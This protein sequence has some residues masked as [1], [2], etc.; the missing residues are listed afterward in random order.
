MHCAWMS[1]R[2]CVF[3]WILCAHDVMPDA[4]LGLGQGQGWAD[5]CAHDVLPD[6]PL[7]SSFSGIPTKRVCLGTTRKYEEQLCTQSTGVSGFH[8][9]SWEFIGWLPRAIGLSKPRAEC[10]TYALSSTLLPHTTWMPVLAKHD[11]VDSHGCSLQVSADVFVFGAPVALWLISITY[12]QD[13]DKVECVV[14]P[15]FPPLPLEQPAYN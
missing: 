11:D 15:P 13:R 7:F 1:Y 5:L 8:A 9:P 6:G 12:I 3:G 4:S 2:V 14:C 10:W